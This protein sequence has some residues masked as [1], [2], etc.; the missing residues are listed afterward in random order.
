M[1]YYG[2]R[3]HG[4]LKNI[5]VIAL[6]NVASAALGL[7]LIV[8]LARSLSTFD[9]GLVASVI[10]IV[11]GSQLLIDASLNAGIVHVTAARQCEPAVVRT[12]FWMKIGCAILVAGV[13][14]VAADQLSHFLVERGSLTAAIRW[15]A[16]ALVASSGTSFSLTMLQSQERFVTLAA[17]TPLK[18][19]VRLVGICLVV[20]TGHAS[21]DAIIATIAAGAIATMAVAASFLSFAFL[22]EWAVSLRYLREM[23]QINLWMVM[24]AMANIGSRLDI[25]LIAAIANPAEAGLYAAALQMCM[26]V[27]I[28][29]QSLMTTMLPRMSRMKQRSEM[30]QHVTRCLMISPLLFIVFA[31]AWLVAGPLMQLVLGAPFQPAAPTF[32]VLFASSLLT[33]AI[34][35]ILLVLFPLGETRLFGLTSLVQLVARIAIA[36][37]LIPKLG[38][39]GAA[40][41]ELAAKS[42]SIVVLVLLITRLVNRRDH[43]AD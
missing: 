28:V 1:N 7:L 5:S 29:S 24:V 22:R 33:L 18:N 8:I 11:D 40:V 15:A 2:R 12:G 39:M 3:W 21:V 9:F 30:R 37:M 17:V 6:G 13:I 10:A 41:A 26:V 36:V 42:V 34:N 38:A 25:W 31:V 32:V 43:A 35:P 19:L 4:V 23:L 20:L 27:G 14:V 16:L